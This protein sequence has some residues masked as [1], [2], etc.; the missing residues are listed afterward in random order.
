MPSDLIR[1]FVEPFW[2]ASERLIRVL[3]TFSAALLLLL[4]G[5]F[6]ARAVRAL[7][8]AA[9]AKVRLD[10]WTSRVGV[11]E[12]L[13]RLGLGKSP[14]AVMGF[15]AHWF[16]L[17]LFIVSAANALSMPAVS[18]LLE[19]FAGFLPS[20]VCA[21]LIV[22]GG[23]LFGRLLGKVV[24]NAAEANSIRG[25]TFAAYAAHAVVVL[26][27]SAQAL[28]QLGVRPNLISAAV[29]IL[30]GSAGLALAVATGLGARDIAAERLRELFTRRP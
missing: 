30:L 17:V 16:I 3:P 27:A 6:S 20:L 24:A 12:I 7:I 9:L 21:I 15:V 2:S 8:D 29:Q 5:M 10:E 11:N 26:F 18:E 25:G 13:A 14:S 28:E 4:F 19:R 23:L 22:F 1:L